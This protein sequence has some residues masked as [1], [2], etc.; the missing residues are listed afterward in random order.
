MFLRSVAFLYGALGWPL[1]KWR[2]EC[3]FFI[4]INLLIFEVKSNDHFSI[5]QVFCLPIWRGVLLV[6]G[7]VYWYKGGGIISFTLSDSSFFMSMWVG[8]RLCFL[9]GGFVFAM[10]LRYVYLASLGFGIWSNMWY[11][12][13]FCVVFGFKM[14][15]F[16][17]YGCQSLR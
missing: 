7:W 9:V 15:E 17:F 12:L 2:K 10:V 3:L 14:F 13:S 11:F 5:I 6:L 16:C 4:K 1:E 8:H